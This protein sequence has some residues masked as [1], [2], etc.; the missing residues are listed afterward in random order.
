MSP[1]RHARPL[2]PRSVADAPAIPNAESKR[3]E[4]CGGELKRRRQGRV[5]AAELAVA[6][7]CSTTA[8]R[9]SNRA[10][11]VVARHRLPGPPWPIRPTIEPMRADHGHL[12]LRL[13]GR[14][15]RI[16]RL[17]RDPSHH[18]RR[19]RSR[20]RTTNADAS[21][22]RT[23]PSRH[24]HPS[25]ARVSTHPSHHRTVSRD[26]TAQPREPS[27]PPLP[28]T[29]PVPRDPSHHRTSPPSSVSGPRTASS[30]TS[31]PLIVHDMPCCAHL[32]SARSLPTTR[33]T[34]ELYVYRQP[35]THDC[36]PS[37][38]FRTKPAISRAG[39]WT[40]SLSTARTW[41]TSRRYSDRALKHVGRILTLAGPGPVRAF[42]YFNI[43]LPPGAMKKLPEIQDERR[44]ICTRREC[45]VSHD[46]GVSAPTALHATIRPVGVSAGLHVGIG[47]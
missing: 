24:V 47:V 44:L 20:T 11:R 10:S 3:Q 37:A 9:T 5:F 4:I 12:A 34:I 2:Y 41:R 21:D 42:S 31:R 27:L 39:L 28:S 40:V 33:P 30:Q 38:T 26:P 6:Q 8:E 35:S 22:A 36:G 14:A 19:G 17:C 43:A 45:N 46:G 15:N 32:S 16:R 25:P 1:E 23:R 29:P 7:K 13:H 18:R